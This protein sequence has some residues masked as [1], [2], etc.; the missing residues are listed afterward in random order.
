MEGAFYSNLTM[1]TVLTLTLALALSQP[2]F[3][4]MGSFQCAN[5]NNITLTVSFF[6]FMLWNHQLQFRLFSTKAKMNGTISV[7]VCMRCLCFLFS[8]TLRIDWVPMIIILLNGTW[9]KQAFFLSLF[10]CVHARLSV[11]ILIRPSLNA[12][13]SVLFVGYF[14]FLLSRTLTTFFFIIF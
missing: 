9:Y 6:L 1:T 13:Y 3:A 4:I 7:V 14:F 10:L 12:F 2:R 5:D 8:A 11:T